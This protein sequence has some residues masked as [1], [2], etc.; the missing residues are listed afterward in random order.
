MSRPIWLNDHVFLF[1]LSFLLQMQERASSRKTAER[2]GI[3]KRNAAYVGALH[4]PYRPHHARE[5]YSY[6]TAKHMIQERITAA[7]MAILPSKRMATIPDEALAAV[8]EAY[9]AEAMAALAD[10]DGDG[11]AQGPDRSYLR[12]DPEKLPHNAGPQ[13]YT[14]QEEAQSSLP[15]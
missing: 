9:A 10:A 15:G 6:P 2:N 11:K 8:A 5:A 14:M 13:W 12:P 4:P 3:A 7:A 1:F